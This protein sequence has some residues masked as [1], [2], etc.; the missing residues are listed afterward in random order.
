MSVA[1]ETYTVIFSP[2][3]LV[4][5]MVA[6]LVFNFSQRGM[7]GVHNLQRN[8]MSGPVLVMGVVC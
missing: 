2:G 6:A 7:E 3:Y 5:S 4:M 1:F 8:R